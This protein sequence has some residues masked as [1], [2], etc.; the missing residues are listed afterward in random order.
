[1][2]L[3]DKREKN[4][5]VVHELIEEGATLDIK[6]IKVAD[7]IIGNIAIERKTVSDFINSMI[8]KRLVRQLLEMKQYPQQILLIEGI[9]EH[10]L[11]NDEEK[12]GVHPNAI[13]GMLLS[14]ILDY[15]IPIIYTKDYKDTVRFLLTLEKR[16]KKPN[17]KLSLRANKKATSISEQQELILE[18][19]PGIGPALAKNLLSKFKTIKNVINAEETELKNVK[20]IST[21]KAEIIKKLVSFKYK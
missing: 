15:R 16:M 1:M 6:F 20:K 7:Y 9:E 4:T 19:F 14:V 21:K 18:G 2:I 8:S 5:P 17:R 10:E 11:Y 13:R 12:G 3:V